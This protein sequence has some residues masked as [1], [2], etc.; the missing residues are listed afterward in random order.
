MREAHGNGLINVMDATLSG[1]EAA[2]ASS[3]TSP[4]EQDPNVRG[5][6]IQ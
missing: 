3:G 5:G 6:A 2:K 4:I 1:V